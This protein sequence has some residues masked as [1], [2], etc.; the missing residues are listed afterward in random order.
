MLAIPITLAQAAA[1]LPDPTPGQI[2]GGLSVMAAMAGSMIMIGIWI[3]RFRNGGVVLPFATRKPLC[4]PWP[5]LGFGIF[6]AIMMAIAAFA[7]GAVDPEI[8]GQKNNSQEVAEGNT[9]SESTDED[10]N[11]QPESDAADSVA[12]EAETPETAVLSEEQPSDTDTSIDAEATNVVEEKVADAP[13]LSPAALKQR[14]RLMMFSN[15]ISNFVMLAIFGLVIWIFQQEHSRRLTTI[16]DVGYEPTGVRP[17][18]VS[19]ERFPDLNSP[20]AHAAILDSTNPFAASAD[21]ASA[22]INKPGD[23]EPLPMEKWSI[24]NE[25]R[26]AFETFLV[27]YLPTT[28]IRVLIVSNAP[29]TQ[30]HPFLE[31]LENGVDVEIM[32]MIFLMAVVIAPIVEELMYR[33][34]IFGGMYQRNSFGMGLVI[35][36]VLFGLAHGYPDCFAL[37]PLAV[38]IGFTY[39]RRRSY[40]TAVLVHFLFNGFN[41]MLA[42]VSMM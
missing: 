4:V 6:L 39:S 11:G 13:K 16:D 20:P 8:L 40:R 12:S 15:L 37:L 32:V 7:G 41:M 36:S 29:D 14:I 27:A 10:A 31:M 35:S 42:G 23:D 17:S 9:E 2:I 24:P 5:L 22:V 21:E 18:V 33:V 34:A 28:L 19:I 25:L 26:F 38:A 1:E 3:A 30:S